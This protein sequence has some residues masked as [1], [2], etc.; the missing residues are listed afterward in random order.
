M[1]QRLSIRPFQGHDAGSS[2]AIP[3][4]S[5]TGSS[6]K[7]AAFLGM[8]LGRARHHLVK[9]LLLS[10]AQKLEMDHCF[11]CGEKIESERDLTIE[12]KL[13]WEGIDVALY[14][15]LSNIAFSH[16]RCNRPH[17]LTGLRKL[18]AP[19]TAWCTGH[20][21]FLPIEKFYRQGKNR[22][23]GLKHLCKE[24]RGKRDLRRNHARKV[25][26]AVGERLTRFPVTEDTAGSSPVGSASLE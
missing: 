25:S 15:D 13:P 18:G 26:G 16:A 8:S 9:S 6:D 12:H 2:P 10:L 1:V 23:N 3:T 4:K 24:C 7:K 21:D 22:W 11:R 19:G 14:W 5:S 17:R 20:Q